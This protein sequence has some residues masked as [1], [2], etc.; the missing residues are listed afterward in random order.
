M[1]APN[2]ALVDINLP[3]MSGVEC[4]AKIKERLPG[5]QIVM[6]TTYE[7]SE[8]IFRSLRAGA[9]GYMLKKTIAADLVQALELAHL[10]GSPMSMQVARKVVD[11]FRQGTKTLSDVDQLTARE[12]EILSLLAKGC[13]YKEIGS[14]L[15][16]SLNTVRSHLKKIYEK[17]HVQS[18]TQATAKFLQQ[19]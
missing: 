7:E 5:L 17:L 9:S 6:L 11:Y 13:L 12:Q 3:N 15:D 4:V 14:R 2:I 19:G 8:M 10:G 18:R 1:N 16:I